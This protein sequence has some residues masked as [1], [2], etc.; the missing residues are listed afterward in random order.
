MKRHKNSSKNL[1]DLQQSAQRVLFRCSSTFPFQL[2]PDIIE[3]TDEIVT[4]IYR[5]FFGSKR[6]FPIEVADLMNIYYESDGL[7]AAVN[8]KIEDYEK[9]PRKVRFLK[10]GD[11]KYLCNIVQGLI[12]CRREGIDTTQYDKA[13]LLQKLEDIGKTEFAKQTS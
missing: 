7:F 12:T 3:V 8:F 2:R 5:Q 10:R 9:P 13:E 4:V 1:E 6:E 11:A